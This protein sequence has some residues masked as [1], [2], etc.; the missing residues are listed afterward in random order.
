[1]KTCLF[2]LAYFDGEDDRGSNRLERN[3]KYVKYYA[4]LKEE[5]GFDE[6]V[7][8]DNASNEENIKK[9]IE[10]VKDE[11]IQV[12]LCGSR[13]HLA[14]K[15]GYDYPYCWRG[16]HF[17]RDLIVKF[18]YKKIITIDSDGFVLSKKLSKY[19]KD[20]SSGWE[21]FWC[22]KYNFPEAAFHI[23]NADAMGYF[24]GYTCTPWER[25][26]GQVMELALPFTK[27]NKEFVC[28][29]FGEDRAPQSPVMD[30]Y[31]Q[32]PVDMELTYEK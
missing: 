9:F 5:L 27:V 26:N 16:L 30:W 21:A 18:Q 23:L 29:R 19:V 6:I 10:A 12:V 25:L 15:G 14:R 31:G 28:D 11:P 2:S 17:M 4:K 7:L 22:Q 24:M 1:M 13:E 20:A 3:I 8:F 32:C